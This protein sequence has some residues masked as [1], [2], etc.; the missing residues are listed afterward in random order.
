MSDV[1]W[2]RSMV[3]SKNRPKMTVVSLS[4]SQLIDTF[5]PVPETRIQEQSRNVTQNKDGVVHA[6]TKHSHIV[7]HQRHS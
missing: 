6:D 4:D 2:Y 7:W 3:L 5:P 1:G